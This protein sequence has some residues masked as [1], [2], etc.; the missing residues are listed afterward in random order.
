MNA[1]EELPEIFALV[2]VL[3]QFI[4]AKLQGI[5]AHMLSCIVLKLFNY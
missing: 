4:K 2:L 1:K 3:C 5:C